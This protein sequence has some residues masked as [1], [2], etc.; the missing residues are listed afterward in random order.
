MVSSHI[1]KLIQFSFYLLACKYYGEGKKGIIVEDG[2]DSKMDEVF[3]Q[4]KEEKSTEGL[5]ESV[6]QFTTQFCFSIYFVHMV[7]IMVS[8]S[9]FSK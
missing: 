3:L 4:F 7:I 8:S 1:L 5:S 2:G 9:I 6:I